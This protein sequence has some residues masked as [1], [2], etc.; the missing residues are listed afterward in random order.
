[1]RYGFVIPSGDVET[2]ISVAQEVEEA[3]RDAVFVA[4][5]IYGIDPWIVLAAIAVQTKRVK[6]VCC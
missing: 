6:I 2:V 3:G 4:D 1:M 5:G